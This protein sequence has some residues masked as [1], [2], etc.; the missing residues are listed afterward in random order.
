MGKSAAAYRLNPLSRGWEG[1]QLLQSTI[2]VRG[3][4]WMI[5]GGLIKDVDVVASGAYRKTT[6]SGKGSS[7]SE[8]KLASL[9]YGWD[10]YEFQ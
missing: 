2:V 9:C 4:D 3:L 8:Q 6:G 1:L 10:R 7:I 5:W